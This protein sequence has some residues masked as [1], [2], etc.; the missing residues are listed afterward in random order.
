MHLLL[1]EKKEALSK[2]ETQEIEKRLSSYLKGK[3]GDFVNLDVISNA[4]SKNTQKRAK[5]A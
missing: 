4:G 1:F 2:K 5:R 3:K